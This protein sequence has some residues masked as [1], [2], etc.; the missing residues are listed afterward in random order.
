MSGVA[1]EHDDAVPVRVDGS[2]ITQ[3]D[4]RFG[5]RVNIVAGAM[6]T[7]WSALAQGTALTMLMECL[8][9][10]G[11]AIGLLTT[12]QYMSM[13]MQ[14]PAAL[15]AERLPTRKTTWGIVAFIHRFIWFIPAILPFFLLGHRGAMAWVILGVVALSALLTQICVP[16][17][18]CWMADLIPGSMRGRFWGVRQGFCMGAYLV[19]MAATGY[20]LDAYPDPRS[21]NGT[22]LGFSI[23]FGLAAFVGCADIIVHLW[24][25]EP[26]PRPCPPRRSILDRIVEPMRNAD[27]RWLTFA[28]GVWNFAIGLVGSFGII[29]LAREYDRA[30][31]LVNYRGLAAISIS[32]S[33]GMI[34]ASFLWSRI[35]DRIG[36]RSLAAIL[37]VLAPASGAVWFFMRRASVSLSLP[38][39]GSFSLPQP[40]LL[41]ILVNPVAGGLY[42]GV[43]LCQINLCTALAPKDG[44]TMAMAVHWTLIGLM[45]G[46]GP[47]VGGFV[48]DEI[49]L[50]PIEW[51]LPTGTHFAF[52]HVLAVG[53]MLI[54]WF[55]AVP[56]LLRIQARAGD[57]PVVVFASNPL[58]AVSIIQNMIIMDTATTARERARAVR[59][60][61]RQKS[62]FA[63][64]DLI[65]KLDDPSAEVREEA[66]LALGRI[67]SREAIDAL[68]AKLE[69]PNSDL[70]PQIARALR[71]SKDPRSVD[72]LLRKLGD[73]D[74]EMLS[75]SARTLGEIGDHRAA[76]SLLELLER[77]R[78]DKVISASTRA[79]ARLGELAA[80]YEILPR[81]KSTRNPILKQSL[82]VAVGDLL[83]EP[84]GFY[85]VLIRE[86]QSR[87]SEVSIRL[88]Q[89]QAAIREATRERLTDQCEPLIAKIRELEAAYEDG[90]V[91]RAA[92][93]LFD[94]AIGLAA[95]SYGVEFGGDAIAFIGELV[96]RDERF[97]IGVWYLDLLRQH[98]EQANLG[99]RDN[100]DILLGI[101][102]LTG[103][104]PAEQAKP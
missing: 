95:L 75:E 7:M 64:A 11:P 88:E 35:M 54:A 70:G 41:L 71:E 9:A 97:G 59:E 72:A 89:L 91:Q 65:K 48:L 30:D 80:I 17:W 34:A 52:I 25:P 68:V 1:T 19:A 43:S 104:R 27:F 79:L 57:L 56:L 84:D 60:L 99:T 39:V 13:P 24:V 66:A 16:M 87:G 101:Y 37:M 92:D 20:L 26:R 42:S 36:A 83:G 12:A 58:R 61:G 82:A 63:V 69:D 96:W 103:W 53:L 77:S 85:K 28:F 55:V 76:N 62:A 6:G 74:R 51:T 90:N 10:S 32:A 78:D 81:M 38:F 31:F 44:R 98:W 47:L 29:Y 8:K 15:F 67:G 100:L 22:F 45:A 23:V 3:A 18:Y 40:I 94:L 73:P 14:I 50:H 102:F 2:R 5:M 49:G 4:L 33:V 86:Q 93:L 21:P 46:L